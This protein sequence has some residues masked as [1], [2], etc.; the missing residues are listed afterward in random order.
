MKVPD[1]V[2]RVGGGVFHGRHPRPL[3]GG[4]RLQQDPPELEI[5]VFGDE[6]REDFLARGLIN[7]VGR[8]AE[9][10][11]IGVRDLAG[12][13]REEGIDD[14]L[15]LDDRLEFVEHDVH[16]VVGPAEEPRGEGR[17]DLPGVLETERPEDADVL[18][19]D[20]V[21]VFREEIGTL[22]P[23][24]D[25]LHVSGPVLFAVL[26]LDVGDRGLDDVRVEGAAQAPVRGHDH[27]RHFFRR[28][29]G[30]ERVRRDVDDGR[31]VPEDAFHGARVGSRRHH[32][33]L[34]AAQLRRGDHLHR[35]GDLLGA[36]DAADPAADFAKRGHGS[37]ALERD[38]E[39]LEGV[40][41]FLLEVLGEVLLLG[42]L[43][44]ERRVLEVHRLH[45]F[46]FEPLDVL[47][48]DLVEVAVG[49]GEEAHHLL[50][51]RHRDV[52]ALLQ[53]L[54]QA[55]SPAQLLL[56]G[57]VEVGAELR[58]RLELAVLRKF[59]AEACRRPSSSP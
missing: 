31:Q 18:R 1:Q 53:E 33:V 21:T 44:E 9:S 56:R 20:R 23:D 50:L 6:G 42:D 2:V 13:N 46:A 39:R 17:D 29:D 3:F 45:Q 52:L 19:V 58:E 26:R 47:D 54:D 30:E 41:Q 8:C 28:T 10:L 27:D 12:G 38:R 7:I 24:A 40:V 59:E 14:D 25:Q 4:V 49:P 51:D 57:L 5:Q 37:G 34:G 15:L 32:P 48:R 55:R 11:R 43:G 36:L 22:P 16:P 35:L